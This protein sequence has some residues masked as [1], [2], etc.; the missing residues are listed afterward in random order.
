MSKKKLRIGQAYSD[1]SLISTSAFNTLEH[2]DFLLLIDLDE[3]FFHEFVLAQRQ[4]RRIIPRIQQELFGVSS[5]LVARKTLF[6]KEQKRDYPPD[7]YQLE[8]KSFKAD[9]SQKGGSH[10]NGLLSHIRRILNAS[11]PLN[12]GP[13]LPTQLGLFFFFSVLLHTRRVPVSQCWQLHIYHTAKYEQDLE[14]KWY[15]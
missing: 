2:K 4:G 11:I 7:Q 5:N 3:S 14:T 12:T 15:Y 9:S 8:M 10:E 1:A 6:L 13:R